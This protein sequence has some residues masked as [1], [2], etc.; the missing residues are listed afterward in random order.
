MQTVREIK[1]RTEVYFFQNNV[2]NPKLDA[3]ILIAHLL[4]IRRLDLYLDLDRPLTEA[5]LDA[6]RPLV[7]RRAARE[8][9]QYII[10]S[11]EFYGLDLKLD[12]RALI[13]RQETEELVDCILK[14]LSS[15][16]M[17]ILDLGTGS[18]ALAFA[19]A[20]RY[21]ESSVTATDLSAAAVKL[22]AENAE[23]LNLKNRV[24]LLE[25]NWWTPLPDGETFDLIVSNPPYLTDLEMQNAEPEVI[26]HEP[27]SALHA[28]KDGLDDF[29]ILLEGAPKYLS[30]SGLFAMET[31]IAQGHTLTS[32]AEKVGLRSEI[33]EDLSKRP[34]FFFAYSS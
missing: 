22:A 15:D 14:R 3:D 31:G 5:Q 7:R 4:R 30:E 16:P 9:L 19:L 18:G 11:T 17:R 24:R 25:G 10:G 21:L 34:R 20:S 23:A 1:K 6:L 27:H 29:R 8:P 12:S 26:R 32:M 2:P 33:V 13:P 28:G